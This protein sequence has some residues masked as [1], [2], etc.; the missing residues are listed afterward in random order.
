M[1]TLTI[2]EDAFLKEEH[3]FR[4]TIPY[5]SAK[6]EELFHDIF[7]NGPSVMTL[8]SPSLLE[9]A[10]LSSRTRALLLDR[11][12][13]PQERPCHLSLDS[14]SLLERIC[15]D[16]LPQ[17]LLLPDGVNVPL[18][19]LL[20]QA[21]DGLRDGWRYADLPADKE[22]W[23]KGLHSIE[24]HAHARHHR[25]YHTLSSAQRGEL[26]DHALEGT[27]PEAVPTSLTPHQMSLWSCDLRADI[28]GTFFAHP[29][30]QEALDISALLTG[31]D[32]HLQGFQEIGLNQR[33]LFEG[34]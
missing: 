6:R 5:F 28:I 20:D 33:D 32:D 17:H 12:D 21:L 14:F 30:V 2:K 11:L 4:F 13:S 22:A 10:H 24:A 26:L 3:L 27:L 19:F 16:I 8:T 25:S 1:Q 15:D 9:S 31:G 7:Y 34:L 29:V 23:E 18:A